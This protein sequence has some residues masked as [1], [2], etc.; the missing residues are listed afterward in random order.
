MLLATA[1]T[2]RC[3]HTKLKMKVSTN[4]VTSL[5]QQAV[6]FYYC[7][8]I[9]MNGDLELACLAG[10]TR[11]NGATGRVRETR[12]ERVSPSRALFPL[13]RPLLPSAC[14]AGLL[15]AQVTL[16]MFSLQV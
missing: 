13:L 9:V 12:E 16:N 3:W 8:H 10:G 11:K 7:G 14:Y 6:L 4:L 1:F 15:R 2:D 5:L